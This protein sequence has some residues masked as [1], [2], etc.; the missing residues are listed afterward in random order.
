MPYHAL[1]DHPPLTPAFC[2]REY[3]NLALIPDHLE[4]MARWKADA[5]LARRTQAAQLDL[6]YGPRPGETL[7]FFPSRRLGAPLFVFIHGG[8]WKALDKADFSWVAPAL[9]ARGA[10]VAVVN[11]GL[12]PE[13][14]LEAITYQMLN[15][16]AWLYQQA[17]ALGFDANRIFTGGHSAGGH[18][19]AMM[20]G[21]RWQQWQPQLPEHL[22]KGGLAISG[23]FDLEPLAYAPF[24]STLG[25]T[26]ERIRTLS[27]AYFVP[28]E[29]LPLVTAVGGA[30]TSEFIRQTEMMSV[31]WKH[32]IEECLILEGLD[33]L[34]VCTALGEPDSRLVQAACR[35]MR[36]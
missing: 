36:L 7:D 3:N 19:T 6:R 9:V 2:E 27:P 4:V 26:P 15:A 31:L 23:L 25:L 28:D 1:H 24:L 34:G 35:L 8:Y 14:P 11:Y 30:E 16:H 18:L 29:P 17:A 21:A 12:A 13:T 33:H 10:A 20:L 22:V 32:S 5:Q